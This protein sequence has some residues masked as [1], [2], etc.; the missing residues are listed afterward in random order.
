MNLN[1]DVGVAI[2]ATKKALGNLLK[3]DTIIRD[4]TFKTAPR[5]FDQIYTFLRFL[6]SKKFPC[7]G[8]FL[9]ENSKTS[10]NSVQGSYKKKY[11]VHNGCYFPY[12]QPI[13]DDFKPWG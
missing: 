1:T 4:G 3:M 9:K 7:A 5:S 8:R 10:T 11:T 13:S 6:E 2:F 12:T